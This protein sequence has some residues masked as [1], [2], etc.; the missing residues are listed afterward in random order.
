MENKKTN[1][2]LSDIVKYSQLTGLIIKASE[3]LNIKT[4]DDVNTIK[5]TYPEYIL[6][7]DVIEF[8][9][10]VIKRSVEYLVSNYPFDS[11]YSSSSWMFATACDFEGEW[12]FYI[13]NEYYLMDYCNIENESVDDVQVFIWNE[14]IVRYRKLLS[15]ELGYN[16]VFDDCFDIRKQEVENET[17]P[18]TIP[19]ES[20][21]VA[22]TSL[23]DRE[24]ILKG[25]F[26][27]NRFNERYFYDYLNDLYDR[28]EIGNPKECKQNKLGGICAIL[29]ESK[30][31]TECGTFSKCMCLLCGYWGREVPKDC[32]LN[33][34]QES[35]KELLN[36][37][38]ILENIP[39]K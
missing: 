7:D 33:K 15:E 37:Y 8:E 38:S 31:I 27:P 23:T 18:K 4:F 6:F 22:V 16:F 26:K 14:N 5:E 21:V 39:Q 32:R 11:E 10:H 9:E 29:Y 12:I 20:K 28:F 34:Y 1:L 35:K 24:Y 3:K 30:S 36:K 19:V 17:L 2:S 25:H 13:E